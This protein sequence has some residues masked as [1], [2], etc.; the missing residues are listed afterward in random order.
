MIDAHVLSDAGLLAEMLRWQPQCPIEVAGDTAVFEGISRRRVRAGG[1]GGRRPAP[2]G[3]GT[4]S[5]RRGRR[6]RP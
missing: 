2:G 4:A 3:T 6:Q 1:P 5:P